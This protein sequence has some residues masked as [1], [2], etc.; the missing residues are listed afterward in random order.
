MNSPSLERQLTYRD[1]T[2]LSEH[3]Q[4]NLLNKELYK[5]YLRC[6]DQEYKWKTSAVDT[7]NEVYYQCIRVMMDKNP[8][9]NVYS[10]YLNDAKANIGTRYGSDFVFCMV[11][12]IFQLQAKRSESVEFFLTELEPH[13]MKSQYFEPMSSFV[14]DMRHRGQ[15]NFY[16]DFRPDPVAPCNICIPKKVSFIE[17]IFGN[18]DYKG[19]SIWSTVTKDYRKDTIIDIVK[20]YRT[21]D[22]QDEIRKIIEEAYKEDGNNE[23]SDNPTSLKASTRFFTHLDIDITQGKYLP[24]TYPIK[25]TL[26]EN[27]QYNTNDELAACLAETDRLKQQLSYQIEQKEKE[28]EEHKSEIQLRESKIQLLSSE[29]EE[30]KNR[31]AELESR[32]HQLNVDYRNKPDT[33]TCIQEPT[34]PTTDSQQSEAFS[35]D[36]MINY[37]STHCN[38]QQSETIGQM[39]YYLAMHGKLVDDEVTSKIDSIE[40]AQ[41][42]RN[43]V[44]QQMHFPNVQQFNNNPHAVLNLLDEAIGT[45]DEGRNIMR[46]LATLLHKEN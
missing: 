34:E 33:T 30:W 28:R 41:Q 10:N 29:V 5:A 3:L 42:Q 38:K 27:T 17:S 46:Q 37:A 20:R 22:E 25:D 1:R 7:F 14:L 8:E 45:S 39:L 13:I 40:T 26:E 11:W 36:N 24:E 18:E 19:Q 15:D 9:E 16:T 32:Y 6:R 12:A 44:V 4:D 21:K 31:Y 35:L 23:I 2:E 43:A